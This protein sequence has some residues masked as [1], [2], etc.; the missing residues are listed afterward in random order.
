MYSHKIDLTNEIKRY[1]SLR[2]QCTR[3]I[4]NLGQDTKFVPEDSFAHEFR[5]ICDR[6]IDILK[7]AISV[8]H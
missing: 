3:M 8:S 7:R 2:D 4:K 6:Q 5:D 1:I